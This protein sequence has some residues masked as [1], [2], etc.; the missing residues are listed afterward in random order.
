MRVEARQPDMNNASS[1]T[2]GGF[3]LETAGKVGASRQ[4]VVGFQAVGILTMPFSHVSFPN[5]F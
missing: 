5:L 2:V 1:I 3:Q 4:L